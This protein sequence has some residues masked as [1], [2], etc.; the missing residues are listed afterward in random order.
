MKQALMTIKAILAVAVVLSFGC[1]RQAFDEPPTEGVVT[2]TPTA[3]V[4]DVRNL[5]VAGQLNAIAEDWILETVVV[6]DDESGNYYKTIVVQDA[7]GGV[8]L[9]IN[10]VG[11]FNDYPVGRTVYIRT[12]G[13]YIGDYNGQIQVGGSTYVDNNGALRLGGIEDVLRDQYIVRGNIGVAPVPKDIDINAITPNDMSTLVRLSA[14]QLAAASAGQTYADV[15]TQFSVNHTV[16]DCDGNTLLLR[17]SGYASF[18][19]EVVP[20]LNGE[21]VGVLGIFGTDIQLFIRNPSDL[22]MTDVR[23]DGSGGGGGGGGS[24]EGDPIAIGDVRALYAGATMTLPANKKIVGVVI[25][26][27][28]NSNTTNK[29]MVVQGADGKGIVVRFTA[30]HPYSLGDQVEVG[31]GSQELSEFNGLLQINNIPLSNAVTT[32]AGV[33]PSPAVMTIT[34]LMADFENRES[35]LVK[36]NG[37]TLSGSSTTYSGSVDMSDGTGTM[38]HYTTS[39]ATFSTTAFPT[40]TVSLTG[41]VGQFNTTQQLSIRNLTDVN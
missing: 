19:G 14:V 17:S 29:N 32:G 6:A 16:E 4:M 12:K 37:V 28:E 23:C 2:L 30:T 1:A 8:D 20:D 15:I 3:T 21:I 25:S 31:I 10:A 34:Q 36:V 39:F 13:L 38:V 33:L 35:T 40:N 18:A 22:T 27:K 11:L 26:D 5:L 9:K 41:I 24:A 7:T